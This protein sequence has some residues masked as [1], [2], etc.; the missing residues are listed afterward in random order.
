MVPGSS[1]LDKGHDERDDVLADHAGHQREAGTARHRQVPCAI[2]TV[3]RNAQRLTSASCRPHLDCSA[4][5]SCCAG[6]A[7]PKVAGRWIIP[8]RWEY[9][10]LQACKA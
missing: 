9:D 8:N 7:L 2:V 3:L 1:H 10:S 6:R 4:L 5:Q